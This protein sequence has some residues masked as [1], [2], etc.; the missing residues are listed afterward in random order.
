MESDSGVFHV[1][2]LFQF[3]V[4]LPGTEKTK[5]LKFNHFQAADKEEK[6]FSIWT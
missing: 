6:S 2:K 5:Q 4:A 1:L 3:I